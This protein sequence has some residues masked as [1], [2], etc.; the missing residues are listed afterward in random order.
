MIIGACVVYNNNHIFHKPLQS[1]NF[2]CNEIVIIDDG[3]DNI[4]SERLNQRNVDV[5]MDAK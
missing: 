4:F 1:F 2:L 5:F 3:F